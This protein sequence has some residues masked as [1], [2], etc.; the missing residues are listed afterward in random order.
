M[1]WRFIIV[2]PLTFKF[3]KLSKN[4]TKPSSP[5]PVV[6]DHARG[7][8]GSLTPLGPERGLLPWD[9]ESQVNQPSDL[10]SPESKL[11]ALPSAKPGKGGVILWGFRTRLIF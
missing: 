5:E 1:R 3:K 6:S 10:S 7:Q 11:A 4:H 2:L 8:A 9:P